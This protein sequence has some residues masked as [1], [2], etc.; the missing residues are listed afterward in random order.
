MVAACADEVFLDEISGNR[1]TGFDPARAEVA[2]GEFERLASVCDTS[3][4]EFGSSAEGLMGVFRGTV[5]AG[6]S[7]SPGL[8]A[9][10]ANAAAKLASCTNIETTACL[11]TSALTWTCAP[12]GGA[13]ADCFTDVNCQAGLHCP[14]PDLDFGMTECTARKPVGSA[15]VNPNECASLYCRGGSCV[16]PSADAAYCLSQ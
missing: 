1:I 14:N 11:P 3:I 7:C 15:C 5:D 13:G 10:P 4:A 9:N 16:E 8:N 6:E 12:R 2:F